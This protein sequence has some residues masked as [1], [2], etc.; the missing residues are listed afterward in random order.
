MPDQPDSRKAQIYLV[1]TTPSFVQYLSPLDNIR[2]VV[3]QNPAANADSLFFCTSLT[4]AV[5]QIDPG[6]FFTIQMQGS[7]EHYASGE[8]ICYFRTA[9]SESIQVMVS[10]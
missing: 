3:V 8:K 10:R 2:R 1:T 6:F 5:I 4:G 7:A 9:N